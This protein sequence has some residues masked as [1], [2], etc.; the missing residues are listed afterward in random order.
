MNDIQLENKILRDKWEAEQK[1]GKSL[2]KELNQ[3]RQAD[4]NY[5]QDLALMDKE[6]RALKIVIKDKEDEISQ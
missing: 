3:Y 6:I 4:Q 1:V 2:E 5:E